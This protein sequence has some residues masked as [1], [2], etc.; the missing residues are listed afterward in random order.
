MGGRR[1][2]LRDN[3]L[4]PAP[5][6]LHPSSQVLKCINYHLPPRR[7]G[8]A[9]SAPFP[10]AQKPRSIF[11]FFSFSV[12]F[13]RRRAAAGLATNGPARWA[14]ARRFMR[15]ARGM[16]QQGLCMIYFDVLW[17]CLVRTGG[18]FHQPD[19][20]RNVHHLMR[21]NKHATVTW[22][23]VIF[24]QFVSELSQRPGF[25]F[26]KRLATTSPVLGAFETQPATNH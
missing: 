9:R 5:L 18:I 14:P 6:A 11:F 20:I 25:R 23:S 16:Q 15:A 17:D 12:V 7:D 26:R 22:S 2:T 19:R 24:L 8:P 4:H 21:K 10:T 1:R 3:E 13:R